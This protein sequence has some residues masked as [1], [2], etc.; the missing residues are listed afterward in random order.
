M[1]LSSDD[2]WIVH[3]SDGM[4]WT[5]IAGLIVDSP[6]QSEFTYKANTSTI[7]A[8]SMKSFVCD[9]NS[10][11]FSDQINVA[12]GAIS[13]IPPGSEVFA[14]TLGPTY[15]CKAYIKPNVFLEVSEE[16]YGRKFDYV[17]LLQ[18]FGSA[19]P[20]LSHL[21][22]SFHHLLLDSQNDQFRN[23]YISRAIAAQVITKC[24]Q[25]N[26]TGKRMDVRIP[27]TSRQMSV[28][29]DFF[30]SNLH[31]RFLLSELAG[32]IGLSRTV[33]FNRFAYT[34]RQTPNQYLQK[35][36]VAQAQ[37]LLKTPDL[38][39]VQVAHACGFSDQSHMARFFIRYVGM[40]PNRYRISMR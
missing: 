9:I 23:E 22:Y 38:S 1:F 11:E 27:L 35:M 30:A 19:D 39:L 21:M 37:E 17:D 36:R 32:S 26:G 31:G 25:A 34:M 8:L 14:N 18:R 15:K 33:F 6:D 29:N 3:S 2:K 12:K 20:V 40:T 16:I 28:I 7:I 24:A 10:I 5:D 4:G 13:I